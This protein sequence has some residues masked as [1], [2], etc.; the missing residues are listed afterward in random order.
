MAGEGRENHR[1]LINSLDCQWFLGNFEIL[2]LPIWIARTSKFATV[3]AFC[4]RFESAGES[5]QY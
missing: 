3:R 2:A 4:G 1:V 5:E